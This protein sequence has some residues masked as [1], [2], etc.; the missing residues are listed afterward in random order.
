M[1]KKDFHKRLIVAILFSTIALTFVSCSED[2]DEFPGGGRVTDVDLTVNQPGPNFT[3]TCPHSFGLSGLIITNGGGLITYVWETSAGNRAPVT[4]DLPVAGGIAVPDTF[5]LT[6][7]GSVT[8]TLHVTQPNDIASE[9]V[10][11]TA[12]CQ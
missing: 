5:V 2:D 10:T 11:L 4:V 12:T 3:G 7:T 6:A 1:L 8:V 9:T